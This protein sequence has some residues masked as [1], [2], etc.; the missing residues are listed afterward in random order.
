MKMRRRATLKDIAKAAGVSAVTVHKAIYGK[1]GVSEETRKK[2]AELAAEMEYSVNTAASSLKRKSVRIAVVLQ[3]LTNPENVF[4]RKMWEGIAKAERELQDYRVDIMRFECEDN[5]HTQEERLVEI[6][7]RDDIDGVILHPSD[8][9]KLNPAIDFLW[10]KNIPVITVNSDASSSHRIANISASND[11]IGAL[12][13]ELLGLMIP[14]CGCAVVAGGS[15]TA[16]NLRANRRGFR[17]AL[18]EDHPGVQVIDVANHSDMPRF[19]NDFVKILSDYPDIVG[20]YAATSRD[21][22]TVCDVLES[23]GLSGKIKLVGSDAF[24]EMLPFFENK[25][26][27]ATI[28]KDQE[29]QAKQAILLLYNYL[30]GRPLMSGDIRV[31]VVLKNNIHDYL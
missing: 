7:Q 17:D 15:Q 21:T 25:T 28:W 10:S 29:A 1:S 22:Y 2:I 30:I 6:A 13:A 27:H 24:D 16:E 31:S 8:E 20:I 4:F 18:K 19:R 3:S 26:L 5:W 11:K 9:T 14:D 23:R 12:A